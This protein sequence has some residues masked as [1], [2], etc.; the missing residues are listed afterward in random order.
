MSETSEKPQPGDTLERDLDSMTNMSGR[1]GRALKDRLRAAVETPCE[2]TWDN[3]YTILLNAD[4]GLGLTLGQAVNMVAPPFSFVKGPVTRWVDDE[5]RGRGGCSVRV[6]GWAR[7]PTA[8]V[9][10]TAIA[11]A[12]H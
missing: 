12:T 9:I 7:T 5:S 11:Y 1:L 3:A 6:S 8:E 2:A 4:V 10:R